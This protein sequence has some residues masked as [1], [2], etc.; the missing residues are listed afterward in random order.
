MAITPILPR[1]ITGLPQ[2][3]CKRKIAH[4]K[5]YATHLRRRLF[6]DINDAEIHLPLYTAFRVDRR[7]RNQ[8]VFALYICED[9][10]T[11]TLLSH[12]KPRL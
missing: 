8:A 10:T 12:L 6:A 4:L 2:S 7:G 11:L 3:K 9:V 1:N 5:Q